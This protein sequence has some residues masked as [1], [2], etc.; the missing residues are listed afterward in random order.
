M[1][2][3]KTRMRVM[4]KSCKACVFATIKPNGNI[5]CDATDQII[6]M[7]MVVVNPDNYKQYR[8]DRQRYNDCP[9]VDSK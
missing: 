6:S 5:Q 3:V 2:Y 7:P 4:P 1:I 9:L 8:L